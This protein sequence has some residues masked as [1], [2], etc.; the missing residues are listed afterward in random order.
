MTA[1]KKHN[2]STKEKSI[3]LF[4]ICYIFVFILWDSLKLSK[5][6]YKSTLS[7]GYGIC[8]CHAYE[9]SVFLS[10]SQ[11]RDQIKGL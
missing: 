8:P 6:N 11:I 3:L 10:Q 1:S 4:F 9:C 5:E 7:L 2:S